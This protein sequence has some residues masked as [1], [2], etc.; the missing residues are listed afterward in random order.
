M[1]CLGQA[2]LLVTVS[3]GVTAA[4]QEPAYPTKSVRIVASVLPGDTCDTL[5]RLAGYKMGEKL[6]QQFVIDNRVGASGM[7][8]HAVIAQAPAD[9]YT[10]GCG[11]GG[12]LAI[13]PHAF[14]KVPYDALNDFTPIA[15]MATNFMALAVGANAPWRS[16]GDL[17]QHAKQNPGKVSFG[18]NGEGAFLHFATELFRS[19]AGFSYLHVPFK[20]FPQLAGDLAASR[21]DAS[22]G[23]FPA[24]LPF[25]QGG[26][27][28]ILGIARDK[29]LPHYPDIPT[30]AE[31]VPGYVSG[32][33]FGVV[34]PSGIP[35]HIV[36]LLNRETNAAL[37]APEVKEKLS[38]Q[39]LD[40]FAESPA[41]FA[42]LMRDDHA[43]Y[44]RIAKEIGLKAQ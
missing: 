34:G 19:T 35:R 29:R 36:A 4:A 8:G 9:G 44:G 12:S 6:G 20:G 1:R 43:R 15:L 14:K 24:V 38:S 13:V 2:A 5:V 39:G 30:I 10:L 28:R 40:L 41:F 32:G 31:T 33:W 18:S 26:R 27:V 7:I 25:T 21:L 42:K 3:T 16:V 17:V 23:S 11:N 37:A 22:F